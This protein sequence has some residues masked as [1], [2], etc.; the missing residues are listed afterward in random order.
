MEPAGAIGIAVSG[1]V[2]T[3]K[4]VAET[5]ALSLA[6]KAGGSGADAGADTGPDTGAATDTVLE[7]QVTRAAQLL[8]SLLGCAGL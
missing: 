7:E 4:G 5:K 3:E 6:A 2:P 1:N 8:T